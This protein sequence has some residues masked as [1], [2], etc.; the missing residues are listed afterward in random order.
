VCL[1]HQLD[2]L[3]VGERERFIADVTGRAA[4]DDPPYTLDY[5]RLNMSG[6][7]PIS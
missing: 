3:P 1:R 5:W 2:R 4:N 6:R 7:R